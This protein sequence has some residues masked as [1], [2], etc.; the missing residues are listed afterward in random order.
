[1]NEEKTAEMKKQIADL[2]DSLLERQDNI[3]KIANHQLT[4][5]ASFAFAFTLFNLGTMLVFTDE[6]FCISLMLFYLVSALLEIGLCLTRKFRSLQIY[7]FHA[8]KVVKYLAIATLLY[9]QGSLTA[10]K[11]MSISSIACFIVMVISS[12][13][14]IANTTVD[15]LQ[16]K[17]VKWQKAV[18]YGF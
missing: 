14:V 16:V 6:G 2:T 17:D 3:T 18:F 12:I 8:S 1:M 5:F 11:R 13:N 15:A 10:K 4:R 7:H 9:M